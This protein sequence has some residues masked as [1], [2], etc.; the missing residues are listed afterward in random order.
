MDVHVCYVSN[1]MATLYFFNH[2]KSA[3]LSGSGDVKL[4]RDEDPGDPKGKTS[5]GFDLQSY[6][7]YPVDCAKDID[8]CI[9]LP[10]KV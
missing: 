5:S 2:Q 4:W 9:S 10:R 1:M 3:T 8:L 6:R 7:F